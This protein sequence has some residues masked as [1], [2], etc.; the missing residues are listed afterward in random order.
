MTFEFDDLGIAALSWLFSDFLMRSVLHLDLPFVL[1]ILAITPY[2][3]SLSITVVGDFWQLSSPVINHYSILNQLYQL[4]ILTHSYSFSIILFNHCK[5][6]SIIWF[7][8]ILVRHLVASAL[9]QEF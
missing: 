6:A 9:S 7:S 3:Q 8:A 4:F 2:Y 1:V 5:A